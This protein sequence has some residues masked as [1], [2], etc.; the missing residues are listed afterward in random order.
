M[1]LLAT[2]DQ[3]IQI[4]NGSYNDRDG[5]FADWLRGGEDTD[6]GVR[7]SEATAMRIATVWKCVNWRAKMFGMLPKKLHE[8][9]ELMGREAMREAVNH[10]LYP[11]IHTAPN[12]TMT[13]FAWFALISA[14]V[15][16]WGNS[17]AYIERGR[18][19]GRIVGLWR[20]LPD[21]VRIEQDKATQQLWYVVCYADG[22]EEIFYP[23]E[24]LHVRGL[25]FD[26]IHGYS[27]RL[28]AQ[29]LGWTKATHQY[30]AKFYKNAFRPSG[31]LI[32]PQPI[33]PPEV[34]KE[35]IANLKAQ[36]KEGGL[37]LIEGAMEY[38]PMS[39]PQNDQQFIET[40]QFQDEDI[41]GI[42]EVK[43]HEVGIM[44]QSTNNNIEQETISSVTRCLA[45]FAVNVEQWFDLQLLSDL[46]SSGRGGGT[47][48]DRFFHQCELK[49]LLR[50]D[51]AAQTAHLIA[52]RDRGIYDGN[53]CAAY[54][55]N[56]P[57]EGGDVRIV[58]AAYVPLDMLPDLAKA[59][60]TAPPPAASDQPGTPKVEPSN[61]IPSQL[62]A[63]LF[64][65]AIGRILH[66]PANDRARVLPTVMRPC[67]LVMS[68]LGGKV[69]VAFVEDYLGVMAQRSQL[70]K[71]E[72]IETILTEELDR[73][74]KAFTE[75][76]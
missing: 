25:G 41:C 44:R 48:R 47:E 19:S 64:R 40:M 2:L 22:A 69:D 50:G 11:L 54:L 49:V 59:K 32:S 53:D 46:P 31:L 8:R 58:N 14:D 67:L 17:Y 61:E 21:S 66:R 6:S 26:G 43:P 73:A 55:G 5:W 45:P 24:I 37:A 76:S 62:F 74:V 38:K 70:W 52:M 56:A 75:G 29:T 34:K 7:V 10:P 65:D 60:A 36:G 12:A 23:D 4:R 71:V 15:H 9:V 72:N 30:S 39:I 16:L 63:G 57:F 51:T 13:S 1:G 18:Y 68:E 3:Q 27:I 42:M 33:K 28:Q 35:L 20:I